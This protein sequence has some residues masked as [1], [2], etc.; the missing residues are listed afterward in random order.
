MPICSILKGKH[1]R[2]NVSGNQFWGAIRL[3]YCC[4]IAYCRL[5]RR[6]GSTETKT[7]LTLRMW[8]RRRFFFSTLMLVTL[9]FPLLQGFNVVLQGS[10]KSLEEVVLEYIQS[11]QTFP[12]H[13]HT[14]CVFKPPNDSSSSVKVLFIYT[15]VFFTNTGRFVWVFFQELD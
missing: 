12:C 7:Q 8:L 4:N 10:T 9:L 14:A 13:G 1:R 3:Y 2:V 6:R 15:I 5:E 11:R